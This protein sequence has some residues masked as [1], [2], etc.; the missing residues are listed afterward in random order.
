MDQDLNT[1]APDRITSTGS[2]GQERKSMQTP[3]EGFKTLMQQPPAA[4]PKPTAKP[5]LT[6]FDLLQAQTLATSP[7][8]TTLLAQ[9][10]SAHTTLGDLSN[11]LSNSNLKLKQSQKYLLK[12]K[13]S[14]ASS[15]LRS[16]NALLG[17]DVPE[18]PEAQSGAGPIA[19]FLNFVT[20][21]QNQ[22][23]SAAD[24]IHK[25]NNSGESINPGDLMLIQIK[26]NKAEQELNYA[27][28]LL[29]KAVDDMNTLFQVQI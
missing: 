1:P 4:G 16:V 13:L 14:E 27:S 9:V 7:S 17:A 11:Q 18:P 15:H 20:D 24:Q 19:K 21:G 2:V 10:K 26:I 5:E 23:S 22:L 6:P 8:L 12:N 29:S 25:L 28:I 3:A